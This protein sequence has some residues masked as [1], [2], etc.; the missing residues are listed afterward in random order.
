MDWTK[1]EDA[2]RQASL[3]PEGA[4]GSKLKA[5]FPGA[6]L[7]VGRGGDILY[8]NAFGTRSLESTALPMTKE[9]VFD[10][11]SLTKALVTTTVAMQLVSSGLLSIDRRL[12]H[13]F[14]TFNTLG[15]ERITVRELLNHTSGYP[16]HSPFYKLVAKA[17]TTD[18]AGIM[19]SRGAVELIYNEIFRMKLESQP[20][21]V[22]RYS[23]VGFILLGYVL[24]IISA[25]LHLD[26]IVQK[27]IIQPLSLRS[28]GFIDL[29][30]IKRRGLAPIRD[31][32]AP[33]AECPWRGR[34][35]WGEVHDDNAYV[36]G[37][38]AGHSGIFSTA[39]DI[40]ILASEL[41]RCWHGQGKLVSQDV[42]RR[43]WTRD[44]MDPEST[45]ALGWDTP[46]NE[47]SSAGKYLD[48]RSV[49]HLGFTGCS[50][51]IDPEKELDV[52]LL[53]NRV[54]LPGDNGAIK[55]FRPL[56]HDLV[57]ETLGLV[58]AT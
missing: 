15:R 58:T 22:T 5:I 20:G 47:D 40:H 31:I 28:M 30:K 45:W 54:N 19:T 52:I 53:T 57:M 56:I 48:K 2:L 36:M 9:T 17:D 6:V 27:N 35:M 43:F 18:R 50:I 12:S 37:G 4:Q 8:H 16:A 11:A 25:G 39:L 3:Q 38:I 51:W 1:V 29:S 44:G 34:V 7:L 10:I 21:K 55:G 32:I 41:I 23:D 33:T 49:G 13:I 24:E 14:Q 46:S 42:I 26:K